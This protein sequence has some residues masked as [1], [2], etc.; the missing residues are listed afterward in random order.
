L[1]GTISALNTTAKT[2]VVRGVT[3]HYSATTRFDDG[4][5]A[6]LANGRQVDVKGTLSADGMRVEASR[7]EFKQSQTP[8]MGMG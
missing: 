5:E 8:V 7:I 2:F 1:N 4:T 3:V 6:S